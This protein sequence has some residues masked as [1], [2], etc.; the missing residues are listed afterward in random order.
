[1][2]LWNTL[3]AH[4]PDSRAPISVKALIHACLVSVFG[5]SFLYFG[6]SM[7][8]TD[9]VHNPYGHPT[10]ILGCFLS[11]LCLLA[12]IILWVGAFLRDGRPLRN[13]LV[14]IAAIA[15]GFYPVVRLLNVMYDDV[16]FM[17]RA[18]LDRLRV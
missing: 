1:M 17:I 18:L 10:M 8:F 12:A 13:I 9:P 5:W 7:A 16:G 2:K 4:N 6:I 14:L 3:T 15:L 11:A